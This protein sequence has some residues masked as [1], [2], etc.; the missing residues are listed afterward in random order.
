ME[1]A[2]AQAL[3]DAAAAK[4]AELERLA[5][6][7]AEKA[8][9]NTLFTGN[10]SSSDAS[11]AGALFAVEPGSVTVKVDVA[12]PP[13]CMPTCK[14]TAQCVAGSCV[15]AQ[16]GFKYEGSSMADLLGGDESSSSTAAANNDTNATSSSRPSGCYS[17]Y[18]PP[19][20]PPPTSPP[21]P[22]NT[23][24]APLDLGATVTSPPPQRDT[25]SD[26]SVY[27]AME[28]ALVVAATF[29]VVGVSFYAAREYIS[30]AAAAAP[31]GSDGVLLSSAPG[32][33]GAGWSHG[34]TAETSPSPSEEGLD[35]GAGQDFVP[36]LNVVPNSESGHY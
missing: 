24:A 2:A 23:T 21:P 35:G 18:S 33:G 12:P 7:V 32:G 22:P 27:D 28:V 34:T 36:P 20:S 26:T 1:A 31:A 9:E 13:P 4:A 11:S 16:A 6:M 15:C 25:S 8:Q 3:A 19:P 30:S 14:G 29:T 10:G 5:T 17:V